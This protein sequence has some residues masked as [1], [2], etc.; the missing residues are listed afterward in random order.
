M[1]QVPVIVD[2]LSDISI[3]CLYETPLLNHLLEAGRWDEAEHKLDAIF[4]ELQNVYTRENILKVYF[5]LTN[6]LSY[7]AH[8]FGY[9]LTDILGKDL[10]NISVSPAFGSFETFKEWA[11]GTVGFLRLK[12]KSDAN[13]GREWIIRQI[14]DY[15]QSHLDQDVSLRAIADHVYLNP[16]YLSYCYKIHTGEGL[17]DYIYRMRMEMAAYY[18]QYSADKI[19]EVGERLG[20]HNP[21]YFIKLFKRYFKVTPQAYRDRARVPEWK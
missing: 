13:E 3:Q 1:R 15:V 14:Q 10:E 9:R 11:F 12:T 6:S 17:G 2:S 7:I 5:F 4:A 16:A 8:K 19:Y 21:S 20:Y 18:L